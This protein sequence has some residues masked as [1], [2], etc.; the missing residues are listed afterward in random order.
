M[1]GGKFVVHSEV[2]LYALLEFTKDELVYLL[3]GGELT[4]D[5]KRIS[6][7][8]KMMDED[9]QL[10]ERYKTC[11]RCVHDGEDDPKI[12]GSYCYSCKR[13]P[14]DDNRIDFFEERKEARRD[15]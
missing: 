3:E 1:E 15:E 4:F 5:Q 6:L 8:I 12:A 14:I 9:S 11:G 13:N 7:Q 2:E 10:Q